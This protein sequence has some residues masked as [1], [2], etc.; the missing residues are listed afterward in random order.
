LFS[1][2]TTAILGLS[3]VDIHPD[4]LNTPGQIIRNCWLVLI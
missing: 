1:K 4:L 2:R 3:L